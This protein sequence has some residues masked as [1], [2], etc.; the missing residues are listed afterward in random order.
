MLRSFCLHVEA[1]QNAL[2]AVTGSEHDGELQTGRWVAPYRPAC[3]A[4]TETSLLAIHLTTAH[5]VVLQL[6][7][8]VA[9][10]R[11]VAS[12]MWLQRA[13]GQ[14]CADVLSTA[15]GQASAAK[16]ECGFE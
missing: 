7:I 16:E 8:T 3:H 9:A 5:R 12:V 11:A 14:G 10:W 2:K 15:R 13:S 4:Q 1:P 6:S